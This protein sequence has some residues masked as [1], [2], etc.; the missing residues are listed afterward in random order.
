LFKEMPEPVLARLAPSLVPIRLGESECVF[1]KGEVGDSL[2]IVD[3]GSV[4]IEDDGVAVALLGEN[5][6]F[7]DLIRLICSN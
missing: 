1:R 7:G 6:V 4:R 2:Y 3:K 5:A